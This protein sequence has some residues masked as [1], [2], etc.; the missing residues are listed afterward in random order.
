MNNFQNYPN[1]FIV[2]MPRSGTSSLY[3]WLNKHPEI[4]MSPFKEPGYFTPDKKVL[5]RR[6]Y[7]SREDYLDLFK[8]AKK[9]H[10][11]F[12][13]ATT[14]YIFFEESAKKIKKEFGDVK[15]IILLRNP[16]DFV[17]S[18]YRY[19]YFLSGNETKKDLNLALDEEKKRVK[20]YLRLKRKN[21]EG[22]FNTEITCYRLILKK[23]YSNI[24]KY[25]GI[26]GNENVRIIYLEDMKSNPKKIYREITRFLE[27]KEF[28]PKFIIYNEGREVKNLLIPRIKRILRK[29][30]LSLILMLQKITK[31]LRFK[32]MSTNRKGKTIKIDINNKYKKKIYDD[33]SKFKYFKEKYEKT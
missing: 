1:L 24:S 5:G 33:L 17:K 15:I 4:F 14:S 22:Y 25:K 29:M 26:F 21:G 18:I 12:G 31:R 8:D 13:E 27:V 3:E 16:I 7:N 6:K 30:P 9:E 19:N 32:I 20:K 11:I 28:Y 10:K 2:G 23:A